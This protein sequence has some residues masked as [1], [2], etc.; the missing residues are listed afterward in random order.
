MAKNEAFKVLRRRRNGLW[1]FLSGRGA[2]RYSDKKW[3]LPRVEKWEGEGD[4]LSV[5]RAFSLARFFATVVPED[6]D[7]VWVCTYG[8]KPIVEDA[9]TGTLRVTSVKLLE[10]VWPEDRSG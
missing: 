10:K 4:R 9:S 5:C 6:R 1:S 3:T 7:E 8:G 2:V